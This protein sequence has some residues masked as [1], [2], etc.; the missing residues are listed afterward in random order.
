MFW[1][2]T[3]SDPLT[4][5]CCGLQFWRVKQTRGKERRGREQEME[6]GVSGSCQGL[7]DWFQ[8]EK[9]SLRDP[10]NTHWGKEVGLWKGKAW[11]G[12][13][14]GMHNP[15]PS[16]FKHSETLTSPNRIISVLSSF[17]RK[18]WRKLNSK[19]WMYQMYLHLHHVAHSS[20]RRVSVWKSQYLCVSPRVRKTTIKKNHHHTCLVSHGGVCVSNPLRFVN[21]VKLAGSLR[22][23]KV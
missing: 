13:D 2:L 23:L 14:A 17:I 4:L 22:S 21:S 3:V 12:D 9:V 15:L 20:R 10:G 11:E 8:M 6:W 1:S 7:T 18:Q 5:S 19:L 16:V